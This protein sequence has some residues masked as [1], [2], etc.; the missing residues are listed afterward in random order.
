LGRAITERGNCVYFGFFKNDR[1]HGF[2][3]QTRLVK[4]VKKNSKGEIISESEA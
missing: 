1:R 3:K 2:G 4:K